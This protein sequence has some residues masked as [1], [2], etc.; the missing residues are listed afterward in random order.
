MLQADKDTVFTAMVREI[1]YVPGSNDFSHVT[2]QAVSLTEETTAD[3][4]LHINGRDEVHHNG[5]ELQQQMESLHLKGLPGDFP[6]SI[7]IDVSKMEPGN[8][9]MVADVKLPKGITSLTEPDR[10]VLSVTH[11]KLKE[12]VGETQETP[13]EETAQPAEGSEDA[14]QQTS[15]DN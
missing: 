9:L 1:Q 5:F 4:A 13:D 8:Q 2:F 3:I 10:L 7:E 14:S 12:E 6:T 15:A 11:P